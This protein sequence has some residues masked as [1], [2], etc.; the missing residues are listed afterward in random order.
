[1]QQ[2]IF[3]TRNKK[4]YVLSVKIF[5]LKDLKVKLVAKYIF[6]LVSF[7]NIKQDKKKKEKNC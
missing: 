3:Y 1:M 4:K 7:K 5:N 6:I 2:D